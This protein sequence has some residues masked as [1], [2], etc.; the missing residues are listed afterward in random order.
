MKYK[1]SDNQKKW[2]EANFLVLVRACGFPQNKGKQILLNKDFFPSTFDAK[3]V[4]IEN[5]LKDL[6]EIFG[7]ES[8]IINYEIVYDLRDSYRFPLAI[9]GKI[10][11]TELDKVSD[12][13]YCI[14]VSNSIIQIPNRLIFCLINDFLRIKLSD[15][16]IP[17]D[18]NKYSENF[19][20]LAGIYFGFGVILTQKRIEIGKST[21]LFWQKEWSFSSSM[22]LENIIYG[23]AIYQKIFSN[24]DNGWIKELP[25][26]FESKI[27]EATSL[28]QSNIF[29]NVNEVE[30][31][32][33]MRKSFEESEKCN[34]I[35]AT[36]LLNKVITLSENHQT[37]SGAYNNLGYLKLK[38]GFTEES[39]INFEKAIEYRPD[40]GFANDNLG[41]SL[42]LQNQLERGFIYLE[43]AEKTLNNDKGY[44]YRNL[45][46]YF[47]KKGELL[48]AREHYN[49]AFNNQKIPIDFLEYHFSELL[50]DI[51]DDENADKFLKLAVEKGKKIALDKLNF[52]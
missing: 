31:K 18:Q 26:D 46:L 27:T 5:I 20:F 52:K 28:I 6:T 43:K 10:Q 14:Y 22:L 13:E 39:S 36:E 1:I 29:A 23:F 49:K 21:T 24:L 19:L 48:K 47:H 4:E 30:A 50:S 2:V 3:E 38:T 40:F 15:S 41:Y 9:Q 33:L 7:F 42:I 11:E 44:H 17:H 32:Y 51:G 35:L 12:N 25:K 16:K 45:G 34:F 37:I 8:K